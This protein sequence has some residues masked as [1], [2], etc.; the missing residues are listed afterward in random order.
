MKEGLCDVWC[1]RSFPSISRGWK[2]PLP[3]LRESSFS[4]PFKIMSLRTS[5]E[6]QAYLLAP[7]RQWYHRRP[8]GGSD[9]AFPTNK[10]PLYV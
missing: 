7:T 1:C 8:A 3:I 10:K 2:T 4:P 9:N 6:Q 5:G